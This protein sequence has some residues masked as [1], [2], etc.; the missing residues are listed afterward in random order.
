MAAKSKAAADPLTSKAGRAWLAAE[1]AKA[2]EAVKHGPDGQGWR[3]NETKRPEVQGH[4]DF[5][6]ALIISLD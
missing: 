3:Y 4:A 1:L 6:R 5:L 2:D